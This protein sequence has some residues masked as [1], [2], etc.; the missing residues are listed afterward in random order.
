MP[1]YRNLQRL[2]PQLLQAPPRLLEFNEAF[3]VQALACLD[4][5]DV[6]EACVNLEGGAWHWDTRMGPA[7][8][9]W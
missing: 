4:E 8:G 3:A 9:S 1:A 5:L 2:L 7:A 6:A